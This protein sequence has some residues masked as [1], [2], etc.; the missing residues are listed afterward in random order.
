MEA[1]FILVDLFP[2][3]EAGYFCV[4]YPMSHESRW[5]PIWLVRTVPFLTLWKDQALLSLPSPGGSFPGL[6][7]YMIILI[8]TQPNSCMGHLKLKSSLV[9]CSV[10]SSS[11]AIP[12]HFCRSKR[13]HIHGAYPEF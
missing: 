8:S 4:L 10:N 6:F 9:F 13:I 1:R 12:S 7:L 11:V 2:I 5:F 3:T